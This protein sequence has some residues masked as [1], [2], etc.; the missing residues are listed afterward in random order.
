MKT[1]DSDLKV[2]RNIYPDAITCNRMRL[3]GLK[4]DQ[5]GPINHCL[6]EEYHCLPFLREIELVTSCSKIHNREGGKQLL[7]FSRCFGRKRGHWISY[8]HLQETNVYWAIHQ[9]EFL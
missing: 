2:N 7:E 3:I 4:C 6:L 1:S 8:Q 5:L 9:L